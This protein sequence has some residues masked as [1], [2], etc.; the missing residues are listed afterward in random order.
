MAEQVAHETACASSL[1]LKRGVLAGHTADCAC[2][3]SQATRTR[4]QQIK[5]HGE[6][7]GCTEMLRGRGKREALP[8]PR[9]SPLS[10]KSPSPARSRR[11]G[12][13][14]DEQRGRVGGVR[15]RRL[16]EGVD[17]LRVIARTSGAGIVPA[18]QGRAGPARRRRQACA[19]LRCGLNPKPSTSGAARSRG[20]RVWARARQGAGHGRARQRKEEGAEEVGGRGGVH[21]AHTRTTMH[22]CSLC[23]VPLPPSPPPAT[24]GR[25][26]YP[27][28]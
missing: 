8:P 21:V 22:C 18:G 26:S 28:P 27:K 12:V 11:L 9:P 1:A 13:V 6:R 7:P 19:R 25:R 2:E 14:V 3:A 20:W 4:V 23:A 5:R 24:H 16:A 17:P 15:G 10:A